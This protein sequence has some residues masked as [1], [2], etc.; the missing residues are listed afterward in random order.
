MSTTM[1]IS[2]I[3]A[4]SI[5]EMECGGLWGDMVWDSPEEA[6]RRRVNA[7]VDEVAELDSE[8]RYEEQLVEF[9]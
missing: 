6:M 9:R 8:Q 2:A 3:L 4:E 7:L 5:R 1:D